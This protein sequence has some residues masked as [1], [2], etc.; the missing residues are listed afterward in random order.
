[1]PA[2]ERAMV[3][4]CCAHAGRARTSPRSTSRRRCSPSRA[5]TPIT[6]LAADIEALPCSDESF[7][8]W[9]SNLTVQWCDSGK[10]FA[11]ARRVLRPGGQLALS[12]LGP[13]T[14]SELRE[15]FIGIDRHRHTLSFSEP[16]AIARR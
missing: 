5:A 11:E 15:A 8:T 9:W 14:F 2:V 4:A 7:S 12:T 13:E 16:E 6:C 3:A 1:M 10:V